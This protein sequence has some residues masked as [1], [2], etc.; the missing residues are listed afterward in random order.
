[1]ICVTFQFWYLIGP[2]R[3]KSEG[4]SRSASC[5]DVGAKEA[6]GDHAPP[7]FG[8]SVNLIS[9]RGLGADY[10][11]HITNLSRIFRPSY[12]PVMGLLKNSYLSKVS[13]S[14]FVFEL[15]DTL[16]RSQLSGAIGT[17]GSPKLN[18][19]FL[20]CASCKQMQ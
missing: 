9:T 1:M 7:Y 10:A 5:R 4:H 8:R 14:R 11:R 20:Y 16:K 3:N 19:E 15:L 18:L 13:F 17:G 12:G 6:W 2:D